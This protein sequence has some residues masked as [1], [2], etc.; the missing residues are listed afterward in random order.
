[1]VTNNTGLSADNNMAR[2]R[3]YC[4]YPP[5]W[6]F[7]YIQS[8]KSEYAEVLQDHLQYIYIYIY[9]YQFHYYICDKKS[10]KIMYVNFVSQFITLARMVPN[11]FVVVANK[12]YMKDYMS[13][14]SLFWKYGNLRNVTF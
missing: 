5:I 2:R 13:N 6:S 8:I 7:D 12:L 11:Y 4:D 14:V 1:M 10:V 9:I 3:G